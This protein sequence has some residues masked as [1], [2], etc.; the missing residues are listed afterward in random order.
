MELIVVKDIFFEYAGR[1]ILYRR[2]GNL[3]LQI[4][5]AW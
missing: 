2:V 4:A 1:D 5:S 3:L